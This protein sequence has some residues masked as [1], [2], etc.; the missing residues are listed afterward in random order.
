V[1]AKR[2]FRGRYPFFLLEAVD[3]AMA[4]DPGE[5]PQDAGVLLRALRQFT[6]DLPSSR[7]AQVSEEIR[8]SGQTS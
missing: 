3:W 2:Q 8:A 6:G 7:L 1:P 4:M 5:R